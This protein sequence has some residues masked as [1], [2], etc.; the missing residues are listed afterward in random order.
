M[1][2]ANLPRKALIYAQGLAGLRRDDILLPS[3]PKS[4]NTWVRFFFCNLISLT[5]W[6]GRTVDFELL[7]ATMPELGVDN[8]L[9]RWTHDV[10]PRVVKTH[11]N[12]WPVFAGR[13][14]VLVIRDPR[15]VMVSFHAFETA[16]LTPRAAGTL[17]EFIR[18]PR[19]GF[20]GWFSHYLSW[21]KHAAMV[22]RYEDLKLG[23]AARFAEMLRVLGLSV[24][25]D[26]IQGAADRARFDRIKKIEKE[27]VK[28]WQESYRKGFEFARS[29]KSGD[30]K[31]L[32]SEDDLAYYARLKAKYGVDLY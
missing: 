15:D 30:W 28:P 27:F 22:L 32:F 7:D 16:S 26:L 20:E 13:R 25:P 10:I 11:R 12:R 6:G 31:A 19:F 14:A 2:P 8:L 17:S 3:F 21:K 4:G 18:H 29:G 23:D 24:A 5:E 1:L 9:K